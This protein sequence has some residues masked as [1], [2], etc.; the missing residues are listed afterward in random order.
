MARGGS[1]ILFPR[2]WNSNHGVDIDPV[3]FVTQI[4]T[5]YNT[6]LTDQQTTTFEDWY[7]RIDLAASFHGSKYPIAMCSYFPN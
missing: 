7:V 3:D 6:R 4:A 1:G 5:S 2:F